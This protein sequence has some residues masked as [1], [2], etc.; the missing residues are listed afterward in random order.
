M[1]FDPTKD[2]ANR[3]KHQGLSLQFG[4]EIFMD[5]AHLILP[6]IRKEDG[7][8]RYKVIGRVSEKFYTA[9]FVWRDDMPRWPAAS[10]VNSRRLRA[11]EREIETNA[12]ED[13]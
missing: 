3:A 4:N 6:T 10:F 9:V 7:E 12:I 1:S 11:V 5:E 8:D 13:A 2:A